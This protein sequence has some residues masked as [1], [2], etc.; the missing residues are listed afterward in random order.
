[1]KLADQHTDKLV[2]PVFSLNVI[3]DA[4]QAINRLA[5]QD[6]IL[7]PTG[8]GGLAEAT[9]TVTGVY[10]T[11]KFSHQEDARR[12]ACSVGDK[13]GFLASAKDS[14]EP[15]CFFTEGLGLDQLPR[16]E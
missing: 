5:F 15:W 6:F 10:H 4:S 3:N 8:V 13:T 14:N 12:D 11:L 2:L 16:C 1:M 7:M 9:I